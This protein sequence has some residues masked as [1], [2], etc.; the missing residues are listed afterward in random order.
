MNLEDMKEK[1]KVKVAEDNPDCKSFKFMRDFEPVL[2]GTIISIGFQTPGGKDDANHVWF[3]EGETRVY[4]WHS[5]IVAAVAAS[6]E[7]RWFFRFIE[8]AGIGGVIAFVLVLIFSL[9]LCFLAFIPAKTDPDILE[10]V[11]LAFTVILGYFFGSQ[12]GVKK[13]A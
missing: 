9:L 13:G 10:V 11:K 5:D 1:A 4:R 7:R 3:G 6:R 12:S 2:D 8:L